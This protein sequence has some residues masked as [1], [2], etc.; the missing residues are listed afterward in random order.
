[1]LPGCS[2]DASLLTNS[3]GQ[4]QPHDQ[5]VPVG[6]N[7][8]VIHRLVSLRLRELFLF[9]H[10]FLMISQAQGQAESAIF[11]FNFLKLILTPKKLTSKTQ[12][13]RL[14]T[15]VAMEINGEETAQEG[16]RDKP[17]AI[18]ETADSSSSSSNSAVGGGSRSSS[19]CSTS[20]SSEELTAEFKKAAGSS[21]YSHAM[22]SLFLVHCYHPPYRIDLHVV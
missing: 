7:I 16:G 13:K 2:G 10:F 22:V 8:A 9:Q 19:S 17:P 5:M 12:V 14:K 4:L 6:K 11:N 20:R 18:P 15:R 3:T 21:S 1:M